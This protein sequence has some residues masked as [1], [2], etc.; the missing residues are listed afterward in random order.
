MNTLLLPAARSLP[1]TASI[2]LGEISAAE[3]ITGAAL[4]TAIG[5]TAGTLINSTAGWLKFK[6]PVDGKIKLISKRP[7][8]KAVPLTA[9]DS[10]GAVRGTATVTIGGKLYKVRLLKGAANDPVAAGAGPTD[11]VQAHGSEWNRLL[12]LVSATPAGVSTEGIEFGKYAKFTNVDLGFGTTNGGYNWCQEAVA[13]GYNVVR[14]GGNV[15]SFATGLPSWTEDFR[16][17]RPVLE[18]V[19]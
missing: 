4:S 16:G 19:N 7:L 14:G 12:Y 15:T 13:N 5:L 6:D 17:W 2:F 9:I 18:L 3:F 1:N 8:R 10:R 11:P